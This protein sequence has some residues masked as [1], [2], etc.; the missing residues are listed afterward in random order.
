MPVLKSSFDIISSDKA[1]QITAAITPLMDAQ[2]NAGFTTDVVIPFSI[3]AS[4]VGYVAALLNSQYIAAGWTG[5][6]LG[7]DGLGNF[8]FSVH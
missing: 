6:D 8:T 7:I 4:M 2:I 3:D 1:A 5:V